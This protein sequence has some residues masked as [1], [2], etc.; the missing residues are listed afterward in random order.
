MAWECHWGVGGLED[1]GER[2][3]WHVI[4]NRMSLNQIVVPLLWALCLGVSSAVFIFNMNSA[5]SV[6]SYLKLILVA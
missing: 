5:C 6:S 4:A 2:D 3:V 1:C